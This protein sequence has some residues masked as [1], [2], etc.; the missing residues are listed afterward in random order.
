MSTTTPI[1]GVQIPTL[2]DVANIETS[3]HPFF[4]GIESYAA[5]RFASS[6]DRSNNLSSPTNGQMTYLSNTRQVDIHNGSSFIDIF[7]A[8]QW[9]TFT[10]SIVGTGGSGL[11]LGNGTL[12]GKYQKAGKTVDMVVK[13]VWGSSTTF[14]THI[15]VH[16]GNFPFNARAIDFQANQ[17]WVYDA[18]AFNGYIAAGQWS[19]T[20]EIRISDH[21]GFINDGNPFTFTTGD[22]IIIQGRYEVS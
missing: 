7:Y 3:L 2:G 21:S 12:S 9:T 22:S 6:T 20:T 8:A 14:G 10:P 15:F 16:F 11:S 17:G 18:S 19:G 4:N 5:F 1:L 13:L